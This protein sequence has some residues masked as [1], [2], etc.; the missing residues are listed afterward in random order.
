MA[1]AVSLAAGCDDDDETET[2]VATAAPV[3]TAT[4]FAAGLFDQLGETQGESATAVDALLDDP[5]MQ[6]IVESVRVRRSI[7][8]ELTRLG[9]L[10]DVSAAD[11]EDI[12]ALACNTGVDATMQRI[13]DEVPGADLRALAALNRMTSQVVMECP[14]GPEDAAYMDDLSGRIFSYLASHT[15][16]IEAAPPEPTKQMQLVYKAGCAAVKQGLK[17]VIVRMLEIPKGQGR[18]GLSLALGSVLTTCPEQ[19]DGAIGDRLRAVI[20]DG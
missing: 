20:G 12:E 9:L 17:Q 8:E 18:Y 14:V 3:A 6:A 2:P 19:L 16:T 13:A 7:A 15:Q 4:P 11:V 5:E 10:Y 1:I